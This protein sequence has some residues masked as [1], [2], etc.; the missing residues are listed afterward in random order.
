MSGV[1][2]RAIL[3]GPVECFSAAK[4]VRQLGCAFPSGPRLS[5]GNICL[6]VWDDADERPHQTRFLVVRANGTGGRDPNLSG[7]GC[8]S[9]PEVA[10]YIADIVGLAERNAHMAQHGISG[11]AVE[12]ELG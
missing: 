12:V 6:L 2:K 1:T 5:P 8:R 4:T 11:D 7:G 10:Q 3:L 9:R